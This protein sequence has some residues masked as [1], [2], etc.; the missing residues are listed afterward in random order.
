MRVL[1]QEKGAGLSEYALIL[2]L[3]AALAAASL[4]VLGQRAS[5]AIGSASNAVTTAVAGE[6]DTN[7]ED[8]GQATPSPAPTE[9]PTATPV[10]TRR[11]TATPVPTR[12]PT[13]TPIPT[14]RPTPRPTLRR[15]PRPVGTPIRITPK[16][17]HHR[18]TPTPQPRP[19]PRPRPPWWWLL[20]WL[21]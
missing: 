4:S 7:G 10:P 3:I 14:R 9:K 16:P 18:P 15:T 19:H 17:P 20:P 5:T 6:D 8:G 12:R 13:A 2:A 1:W 21:W 11:P